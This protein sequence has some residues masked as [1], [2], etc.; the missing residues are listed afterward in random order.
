MYELNRRQDKKI[1]DL[2]A[3]L[4]KVTAELNNTQVLIGDFMGNLFLV[5]ISGKSVDSSLI[6]YDHKLKGVLPDPEIVL[7]CLFF[8]LFKWANGA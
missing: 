6:N 3:A 8:F 4:D 2:T 7:C 5:Y 1:A